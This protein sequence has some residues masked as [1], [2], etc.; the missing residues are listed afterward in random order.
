MIRIFSEEKKQEL[1]ALLDAIELEEWKSFRDRCRENGADYGDWAEKL[2]IYR[3]TDAADVY[4]KE[5][6]ELNESAKN[7]V[8]TV[9]ENVYETDR[10]YAEL[11]RGYQ[12]EVKAQLAQVKALQQVIAIAGG[13]GNNDDETG[14]FTKKI[15]EFIENIKNLSD[16]TLNYNC[17]LSFLNGETDT[18]DYDSAMEEL[19]ELYADGCLTSEKYEYFK[20]M[21]EKLS[22]GNI[23]YYMM[24]YFRAQMRPKYDEVLQENAV[25]DAYVNEEVLASLKWE[26]E[27]AG[28]FI[29][30][31]RTCMMQNGIT[32][33]TSVKFFLITI[34]HESKN[35][36]KTLESDGGDDGYFEGQPLYTYNTRGAGLIQVSGVTQK[37]FVAY[38]INNT[39]DWREKEKLQ[40][41]L[42]GYTDDDKCDNSVM[43]DGRTASE[44]I[45]ENYAIESAVWFW[46]VYTEKVTIDEKP[47]TIN[48]CVERY[49]RETDL[50]TLF[51]AT[52]DAVNLGG[53]TR[54]RG[55]LFEPTSNL[56]VTDSKWI[57]TYVDEEGAI[58]E[59]TKNLPNNWEKRKA[60]Y[61]ILYGEGS[62]EDEANEE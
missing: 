29:E 54:T 31:L 15:K 8:E 12:E 32:N 41:L 35:G 44:Y 37:A 52:Q 20:S 36:E 48:E 21:I 61:D 58:Q 17:V 23:P 19:D 38:L 59:R 53:S 3:Y 4:Q 30:E 24:G 26:V 62:E 49:E 43:I 60:V 18:F 11:F 22:S 50:E 1:F 45:A 47:V 42:N 9:F 34:T 25:L 14:G 51:L 57:L 6:H 33:E 16:I 13:D 46:G 5:I 39:D 55:R 40:T 10:R 28:D 2:D 7:Q 27:G 56:V